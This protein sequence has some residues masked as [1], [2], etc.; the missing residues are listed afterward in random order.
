MNTS[1]GQS[2]KGNLAFHEL[3]MQK[4][5]MYQE[6]ELIVHFKNNALSNWINQARMQEHFSI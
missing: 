4:L 2:K 1:E 6:T 5:Q 3:Q